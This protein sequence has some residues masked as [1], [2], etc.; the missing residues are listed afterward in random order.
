MF[1]FG[2]SAGGMLA[3]QVANECENIKG[4]MLTCILD[5]GNKHIVQKTAKP[6]YYSYRKCIA[7]CRLQSSRFHE[8]TNENGC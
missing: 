4:I 1:L 5:L 2:L 7:S 6:I 3:Y 8:N